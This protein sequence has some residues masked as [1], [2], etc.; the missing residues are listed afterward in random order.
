MVVGGEFRIAHNFMQ[1]QT[2]RSDNANDTELQAE[3]LRHMAY[4]Q[5]PER[6]AREG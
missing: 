6:R 2:K 4:V 5:R 1:R 3:T